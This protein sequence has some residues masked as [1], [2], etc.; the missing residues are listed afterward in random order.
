[1]QE[2]ATRRHSVWKVHQVGGLGSAPQS[3][4]KRGATLAVW[5]ADLPIN[6]ITKSRTYS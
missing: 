6:M 2:A 1:M 4:G 3:A 5:F